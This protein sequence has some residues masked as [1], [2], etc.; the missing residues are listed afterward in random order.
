MVIA[1]ATMIANVLVYAL[2]LVLNRTLTPNDLGAVAALLNLTIISG[3]LALALQLVAAR[4][5]ATAAAPVAAG[6]G[7][8]GRPA[9]AHD[10]GGSA[11]AT[12]L[13]L[14]LVVSGVMLV[15]SPLVAAAFDLDGVL[16]AVLVALT[17][18]PT[19]LTYAA[20]GCL[21]GRERFGLLGLVFVVVALGRF[22]AGA[23]AALAGLGVTGVW[24]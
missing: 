14:G 13:V 3:V 15:A 19:Y 9:E 5:V 12:G 21:L 10:T 11:L 1:A 20:Q 17:V 8:P 23:G 16:P 22:V 7:D 24:R 4:H 6:D 2:F 18:L